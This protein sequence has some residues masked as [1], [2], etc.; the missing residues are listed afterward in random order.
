MSDMDARAPRAMSDHINHPPHYTRGSVECIDV[1]EE[2]ELP[3]HLGNVLKYIW[4]A[5]HKNTDYMDDL[6]KAQWY[7]NRW[8]ERLEAE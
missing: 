1:I 7:L 3:Y 4:R 5:G 8:I 2:L 6:R